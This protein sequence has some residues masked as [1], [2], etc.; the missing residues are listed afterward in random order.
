M[1]VN[2]SDELTIAKVSQNGVLIISTTFLDQAH[3]YSQE[4]LSALLAAVVV[5]IPALSPYLYGLVEMVKNTLYLW[6]IM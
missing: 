5:Y 4:A 2:E 1:S 6:W 3:S